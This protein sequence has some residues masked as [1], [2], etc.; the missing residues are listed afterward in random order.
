MPRRYLITGGAGF[1]GSNYAARLIGQGHEVI[2]YDNLS[3]AGAVRNL[4]WLR[5]TFGED[6]YR[7][8]V[9]DVRDASR[10]NEAVQGVDVIVHLAAQVAV[11]TSVADPRTDFEINALGTFNVLEAARLS[12]RDPIVIYA[13]TNKVYGGMENVAVVEDETRWRYQDL[14]EGCPETQP[15]DF[16]SPYGCSK[17]CGDQYVRDYARIY[18]LPTVVMRQSCIYGP[19]QFGVEDQGWVAWFVIAALLKRRLTIYGD[20]KQVRDL[21]FIDDLL[22]AYDAAIECIDQVAGQ[23]FNIGGG[24]QNSISIWR[25]FGPLLERLVGYPIPVDFGEWRPGDQRVYISDIRKARQWLE[26]QPKVGVE[27]GVERLVTWVRNNLNLF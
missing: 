6:A 8:I 27:E 5:T 2:L 11:T 7:L 3:R 23:I 25:E 13:S 16:H 14:P 26:W 24:P 20:G 19:R 22:D 17:G 15:L 12:G 1:I 10:L 4:E 9:A 21:L 18:G